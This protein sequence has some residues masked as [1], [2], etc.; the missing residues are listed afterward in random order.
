MEEAEDPELHKEAG[1]EG[2]GEGSVRDQHY[3]NT[4][5]TWVLI[6]YLRVCVLDRRHRVIVFGK[7]S[8]YTD[9]CSLQ[10]CTRR[11]SLGVRLSHPLLGCIQ[12]SCLSLIP[13]HSPSQ[14]SL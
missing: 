8:A 2:P 6:L 7:R 10:K 13:S 14:K 11:G 1:Q 9:V 12:H 4:W 3:R 5:N